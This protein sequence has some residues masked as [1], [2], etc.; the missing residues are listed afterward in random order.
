M[1]IW[2]GLL[3][4]ASCLLWAGLLFIHLLPVSPAL[5]T[6]VYA[7]VF[8][9]AEIAFWAGCLLMGAEW[10]GKIWEKIK[11]KCGLEKK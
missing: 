4:A 9:A 1:K 2:G 11:M 3:I 8:I 7:G 10:A 6:A 5:K